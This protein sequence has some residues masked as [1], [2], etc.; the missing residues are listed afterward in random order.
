MTAPHGAFV[1]LR[2]DNPPGGVKTCLNTKLAACEVTVDDRRA[3][4]RQTLATAHRA[5]FEILTDAAEHS[6]PMRA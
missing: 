6:V 4:R 3:R 1:G 5:A 2:Y